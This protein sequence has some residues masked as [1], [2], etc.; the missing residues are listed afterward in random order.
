[1]TLVELKNKLH[2]SL[3]GGKK[4]D[5]MYNHFKMDGQIGKKTVYQDCKAVIAVFSL[6]KPIS[7]PEPQTLPPATLNVRSYY[8][9]SSTA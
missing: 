1:V 3:T 8:W 4:C 6:M 2:M 7:S 9:Q 5:N